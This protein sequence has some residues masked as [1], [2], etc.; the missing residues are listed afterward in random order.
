[1]RH[2]RKI[3]T[4]AAVVLFGAGCMTLPTSPK[5][6]TTFFN[7]TL[8]APTPARLGFGQ[9]PK[10]NIPPGRAK[11]MLAKD[12]PNLPP[13]I[14]VLRLRRGTPDDTQLRNL[15]NALSIPA[16]MLGNFPQTSEMNLE[17]K[18][19]Q[20]FKWSYRASERTLEFKNAAT[21]GPL[22]LSDLRSYADTMATADTFIFARGLRGMYYRHGLV[23][24]DWY[25]WWTDAVKRKL[26]MSRDTVNTVRALAASNAL[27]SGTLP[28]LVANTGGTCVKPEFPSRQAIA[29][30]ALIDEQD[31]VRADGSYL[32][33][34]EIVVDTSQNIVTEGRLNMFYDP[35]RSDYPAL[36]KDKIT[37]LL[38]TGGLS[39][40]T[41]DMTLTEFDFVL[42]RLD[43]A[44]VASTDVYLI[45]SILGQGTR[46][47]PDGSSAPFRIV[48]PLLA[49]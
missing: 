47:L 27:V 10:I 44:S 28:Q 4:L 21:S 9:L 1:M 36:S 34:A 17:W 15:T 7:P 38:S 35:E 41:G 43:D 3:F 48:A 24:P 46:T 22:T 37:A 45:P 20:G 33:G 49:Q 23:R 26:C 18:D 31:V 11:V 25:S 32:D 12:L 39:G 19:D 30:R 13:E 5:T 6:A 14:T 16:Q 29:Y 42:L 8:T 2:L 40:A